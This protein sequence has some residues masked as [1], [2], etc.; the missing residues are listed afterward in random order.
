MRRFMGAFFLGLLISATAL[1][2]HSQLRYNSEYSQDRINTE[3]TSFALRKSGAADYRCASEW[4]TATVQAYLN[5]TVVFL[6]HFKDGSKAF[7]RQAEYVGDI[8]K[9]TDFLVCNQA[10]TLEDKRGKKIQPLTRDNPPVR[11]EVWIGT[12]SEAEGYSPAMLID[13]A[14]VDLQDLEYDQVYRFKDC[15]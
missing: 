4:T 8:G 13:K 9:L 14:C 5:D 15:P 6:W 7:A 11:V 3:E 2:V 1:P 10:A 12:F